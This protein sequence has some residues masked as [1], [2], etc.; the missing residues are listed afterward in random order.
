MQHCTHAKIN[1]EADKL[2]GFIIVINTESQAQKS[3]TKRH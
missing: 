1:Q 3:R 2:Y